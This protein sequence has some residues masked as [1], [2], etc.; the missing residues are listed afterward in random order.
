M[1]RHM[2]RC[3]CRELLLKNADDNAQAERGRLKSYGTNRGRIYTRCGGFVAKSGIELPRK[4][5]RRGD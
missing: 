4:R 5:E 2:V 1:R 3:F